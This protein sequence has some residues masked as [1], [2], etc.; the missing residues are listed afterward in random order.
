MKRVS[1]LIVN[2]GL[3]VFTISV[4]QNCTKFRGYGNISNQASDSQYTDIRS[5]GAVGDGMQINSL[6]S[7][8]TGSNILM[9]SGASFTMADVGKLIA[10][11][12][13]GVSPCMDVTDPSCPSWLKGADQPMA[14]L[15]HLTSVNGPTEVILDLNA[16]TTVS[17]IKTIR[18]GTDNSVNLQRAIDAGSITVPPGLFVVSNDI[19][20]PG[21]RT[22]E[23]QSGATLISFGGRFSSA[24][25]GVSNVTWTINGLVQSI[26]MR[27]AGQQLD[28]PNLPSEGGPERGFIEFGGRYEQIGDGFNVS[29]TGSVAGD[30]VGT[31]NLRDGWVFEI[32]RRGI[33]AFNAKNVSVT[34]LEVSGFDG[35]AVYFTSY[36]ESSENVTFSRLHVHHSRFNGVNFNLMIPWRG[37]SITDNTI[38]HVY[39]GIE[40]TTGLI[41]RNHIS[42]TVFAGILFG[43]GGGHGPI[44]VRDNT[45]DTVGGS[46]C[47]DPSGGD[48]GVGYWLRFGPPQD[49]WPTPV[50]GPVI[51]TN[52]ISSNTAGSAYVLQQIKTFTLNGNLAREYAQSYHGYGI[53]LHDVSDGIV[54]GNSI[55]A[56]GAQAS[57]RVFSDPLSV[58]NVAILQLSDFLPYFTAIVQP[59]AGAGHNGGDALKIT[60][61]AT[62]NVSGNFGGVYAN[63]PSLTVG[64]T[65]TFSFWAAAPASGTQIQWNMQSGSGDL[66]CLSG[67]PITLTT[68]LQQYRATCTLDANKP[69]LYIYSDS[70]SAAFWLDDIELQ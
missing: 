54:S 43:F 36:T 30:W 8:T 68:T 31:P 65:Y 16:G 55:Q 58:T 14:L 56:Q 44:T 32:N 40:D 50:V 21:N 5:F 23:V 24:Q 7:I 66:N 37:F 60:A 45:V 47:T 1:I 35:E 70:A 11:P 20:I 64:H 38:D 42:N 22:I 13:A 67:G 15:A 51:I 61:D 27:P 34:D 49:G 52:N 6:I 12:G 2:L 48:C 59:M 28:W 29:G 63:F 62:A 46:P 9:V 17:D 18:Y 33:A 57:G 41:A 39:T 4:F 53:E 69:T 3:I 10:V 26:A 25:F 19:S